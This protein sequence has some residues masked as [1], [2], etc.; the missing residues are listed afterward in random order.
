MCLF[1]CLSVQLNYVCV[2]DTYIKYHCTS[3]AIYFN[4]ML[5]NCIPVHMSSS[6]YS[7]KLPCC[8]ACQLSSDTS[9]LLV[10]CK[11]SI[12]CSAIKSFVTILYSLSKD[13]NVNP[14][15]C[16]STQIDM[17]YIKISCHVARMHYSG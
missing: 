9:T 15:A 14:R 17:C 16:T 13:V 10:R 11:P 7:Y 8:Q 4:I 3:V 1:V 2:V 5:V 12:G 6:C